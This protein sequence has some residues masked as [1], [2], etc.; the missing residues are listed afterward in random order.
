MIITMGS[1]SQYRKV[2]GGLVSKATMTIGKVSKTARMKV[3]N[4]Q[5]CSKLRVGTE[6][7]K[8]ESVFP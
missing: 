4:D 1:A 5:G 6:L 3:Y 2:P 7:V 8:Y